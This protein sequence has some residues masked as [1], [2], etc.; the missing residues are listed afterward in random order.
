MCGHPERI[1]AGARVEDIASVDNF[2]LHVFERRVRYHT[3]KT[4]F[5]MIP[6]IFGY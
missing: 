2:W 4:C 1:T 3:V 5:P 6:N